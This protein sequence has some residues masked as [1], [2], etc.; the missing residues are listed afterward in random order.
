MTIFFSS[1]LSRGA[2]TGPLAERYFLMATR[3]LPLRSFRARIASLIRLC[4]VGFAAFFVSAIA[5]AWVCDCRGRVC[6]SL[7]CIW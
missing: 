6:A 1:R 4:I 3:E 7:Y 5:A 2:S